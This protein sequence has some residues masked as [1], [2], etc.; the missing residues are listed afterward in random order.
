MDAENALESI[1]TMLP[2]LR[3]LG[4]TPSMWLQKLEFAEQDLL[5]RLDKL[6][7]RKQLAMTTT[8]VLWY[9]VSGRHLQSQLQRLA[10]HI[11]F[12]PSGD[13]GLRAR[14]RLRRIFRRQVWWRSVFE[15]HQLAYG[16]LLECEMELEHLLQS[17]RILQGMARVS[18]DMERLVVAGNE[19]DM[20]D[21]FR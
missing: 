4:Q 20:V 6:Q 21:T 15:S 12:D 8:R 2:H 1:E 17:T 11:R 16:Q 14:A 9:R 19:E 10:F 7:E 13:G 18:L 5:E 3:N